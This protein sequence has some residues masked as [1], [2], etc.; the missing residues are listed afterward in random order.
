MYLDYFIFTVLRSYLS[1]KNV[2]VNNHHIFF[3][4]NFPYKALLRTEDKVNSQNKMLLCR[5]PL[6]KHNTV[7]IHFS[8]STDRNPLEFNSAI[9]LSYY[10]LLYLPEREI[11]LDASSGRACSIF[12]SG[13]RWSD[14]TG[15]WNRPNM[16]YLFLVWKTLLYCYYYYF[17]RLLLWVRPADNR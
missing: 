10:V 2:L 12:C 13:P 15:G 7:C 3:F 5:I 6:C 4:C 14:R 11:F 16:K 9:N 17:S 1:Y 8:F